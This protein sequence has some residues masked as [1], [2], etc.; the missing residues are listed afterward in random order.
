M[1]NISSA[2]T[3]VYVLVPRETARWS[4]YVVGRGT[5]FENAIRT[6]LLKCFEH[7]DDRRTSCVYVP[8]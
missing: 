1:A 4:K 8:T 2:Q 7:D 5:P 3:L 6:V